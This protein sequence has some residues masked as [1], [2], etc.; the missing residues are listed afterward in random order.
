[1]RGVHSEGNSDARMS[2]LSP[3][4]FA[5]IESGARPLFERATARGFH[6]RV[7]RSVVEWARQVR[8]MS[9]GPLAG[10]HVIPFSTEFVPHTIH[11]MD[12]CDDPSIRMIVIWEGIR[13]AKTTACL[14]AI[15]RTVTDDPG[16][17]FSVHPTEDD[18]EKFDADDLEPMIGLA[19]EEW[20]VAKK[21]RDSG[22]TKTFKK[23]KGGSIRI[24]SAGSVTKFRGSTVKVLC[25]HEADA[26]DPES[27]YKALGRT[28]GLADAIIIL[29]STGTTA[30]EIGEGGKII[31]HSVIAEHYAKGDQQKWWLE[32]AH[33]HELSWTKF[34]LFR[35]PTG[36]KADAQWYCERCGEGH[37]EAEWF[38]AA[39][40][41]LWLPTAGLSEDDQLSIRESHKDARAPQPEVRSYWRNGFNSLF[42][43]G[44]G[45]RTKLHE[46]LAEGESA[47]SSREALKTW[48]N[49]IAAELWDE[50][51][52]GEPAPEWEPLR[53]RALPS[54]D[55]ERGFI[56]PPGVGVLCGGGDVHPDRIEWTWLG[57][58]RGEACWVL[59]HEVILGDTR[60]HSPR[61][62]W[63]KL[64]Q[65]L[66]RTFTHEA[67]GTIGLDMGL[68]DA[69]YGWDDVLT[70]LRS[71]VM[72][73]KL[74]A[75]RGA[76]QY[77][78][79]VLGGYGKIV[80]GR[81][82][83]GTLYGHFVGTDAVKDTLYS[84]LRLIETPEGFPDG[85]I[86]FFDR[87]TPEYYQQLTAEKVEIVLIGGRE[88]RR[89]RKKAMAR[90]ETTDTWV[91]GYA[92]F[93]RNS[94]WDFD[95]IERERMKADVPPFESLAQENIDRDG[96]PWNPP[97]APSPGGFGTG[98]NL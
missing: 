88:E 5:A 61:G 34:A 84:R 96:R 42:P 66:Q 19:L 28:K 21:S 15:G 65:E 54:A 36:D 8:K 27:I 97:R 1:M 59:A 74:R 82:G 29:E 50:S 48:T 22:R 49:E 9:G 3:E 16:G 98:W 47:K 53:D 80:T 2:E 87:L 89:Y 24:V 62:P 90:N 14:N 39:Q 17:I 83:Q 51:A 81:P 30:S 23:F 32:C 85:W 11:Q 92:A 68:I 35:T 38:H 18:A 44:K 69:G 20:F 57:F 26:L 63:R 56:V 77:P 41:G 13:D 12:A 37:G 76:S 79:P 46:F 86:H 91:Y 31:W 40:N 52:I 4:I 94:R 58:G 78:A 71:G 60:D 75:C 64:R 93:R 43:K 33:C 70:F 7:K 6:R 67:G 73:G 10:S 55:D 72:Q 95:A 25:L 45:Y